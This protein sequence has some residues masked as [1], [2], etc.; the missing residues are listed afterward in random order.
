MNVNSQSFNPHP[1]SPADATIG[2]V[3]D[4][5][6]SIVSILIRSRPRMR[7]PRTIQMMPSYLFQSS[8]AVARGCDWHIQSAIYADQ[9]FNPH[10]QSPA[11]ATVQDLAL[12][13]VYDVSILIRSRPRMRLA[14]GHIAHGEVD[15]S[16]L[17]RSRPRMRPDQISDLVIPARFQSS[18]AVARGCDDRHVGQ[19]LGMTR[20]NPHPQ[21]PADATDC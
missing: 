21:S 18:S 1:Q 10:P 8:S 6:V 3:D 17:I 14:A 20:F 4:G 19:L 9:S 2:I 12:V 5:E 11:D 16:I 15:V 13:V 7:L